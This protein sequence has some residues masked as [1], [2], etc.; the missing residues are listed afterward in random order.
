[1]NRGYSTKF[2]EAVKA[3]DQSKLGVRLAVVCIQNNISAQE[4]AEFFKVSRMTVYNWFNGKSKVP[5]AH[6]DKM[7]KLVEKLS[8]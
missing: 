2:V 8:M 6:E 5:T 7:L 3:G 1:M 4:V